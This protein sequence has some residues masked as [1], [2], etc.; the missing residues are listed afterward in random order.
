[1]NTPLENITAAR[2]LL[3]KQGAFN[4]QASGAA[5]T[6]AM[7][8]LVRTKWGPADSSMS[9]LRLQRE[10][11]RLDNIAAIVDSGNYTA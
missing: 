7:I 4:G 1:M 8:M 6:D 9:P 2:A 10:I 3:V 11:N 5:A